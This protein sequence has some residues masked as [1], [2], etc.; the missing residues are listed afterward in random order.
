MT[1]SLREDAVR[2]RRVVHF[3]GFEPL[4]FEAHRL[5]YDRALAK[6]ANTFGFSSTVGPTRVEN[7]APVF[8]VEA[9]GPNWATSTKVTMLEH[10]VIINQK[11]GRPFWQAIA[12]GYWAAFLVIFYG[13]L[14]QYFKIA[15]RFALFFLF[16]FVLMALGFWGLYK[17][18]ALP[19]GFGLAPYNVIWS[20]PLA[21]GGFSFLF[22]PLA[23][24]LQ[25]LLLFSNWHVAVD[26]ATGRNPKLN[27]MIDAFAVSMDAIIAEPADEYVISAH[28]MGG[29]IL[30][31]A[32]GAV[33]TRN[34]KA[35]DGKRIVICSMGGAG[36]QCTLLRPAK[37]LRARA[38]MI[39]GNPNVFWMDVQCLTDIVNFYTKKGAQNY[40][41]GG[42]G[43]P[44]II[45]VRMKHM[46]SVETYRRIK[47][48]LLR[49]HR[50]FVM[51][52]EKRSGFDFSLLTAGPFQAARFAEFSNGNLPPMDENGAVAA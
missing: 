41:F 27:A 48:D 34:P 32:L 45:H 14:L 15:W 9:K 31:N 29:A 7:G 46:L 38:G 30:I 22:L 47:R 6:S 52:S 19:V 18:A 16:P 37:A 21:I 28:S 35:F 39:L 4:D 8:D 51:G 50:Q 33:L 1:A 13:G 23:N 25:T 42:K 43:E 26:M 20:I 3:P 36:L 2:I 24:R 12:G 11:I 17:I 40:A 5:R 44:H 10:S 49:V